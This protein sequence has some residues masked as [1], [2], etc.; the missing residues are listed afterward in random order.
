[1]KTKVYRVSL[2][3]DPDVYYFV[4][5][6]NKRVARWCGVAIYNHEYAAFLTAK[7]MVVKRFKYEENNDEM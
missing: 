3:K 1:M 6:P 5:A 2:K 7:D 4:D